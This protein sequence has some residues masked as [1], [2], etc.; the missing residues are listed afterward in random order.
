MKLIIQSIA[1]YDVSFSTVV[2]VKCVYRRFS[3]FSF[4]KVPRNDIQNLGTGG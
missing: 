3:K 1:F 4:K 2:C